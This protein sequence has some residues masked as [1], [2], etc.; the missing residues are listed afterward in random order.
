MMP[1]RKQE[2]ET[3]MFRKGDSVAWDT[4]QGETHG[5]VERKLTSPIKIKGHDVAASPEKPEYLVKSEKTGA[6]AA[7]KPG[8]L[9]KKRTA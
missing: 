3:P 1:K 8:A 6:E 4:P 5:T 2:P 9:R 7:H